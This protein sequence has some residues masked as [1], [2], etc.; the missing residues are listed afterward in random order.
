[1][2]ISTKIPF[3]GHS[4]CVFYI[5]SSYRYTFYTNLTTK[6]STHHAADDQQVRHEHRLQE[7]A[8]R[9]RRGGGGQRERAAG[10]VPGSHHPQL[11]LH[12]CLRRSHLLLHKVSRSLDYSPTW[13]S[14]IKLY[15][16]SL[17]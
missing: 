12:G 1:M 7:R 8:L 10:Q 5:I 15:Q 17:L 2:A 13:I 11:H 4:V 14:I 9:Q 16:L 6:M 3:F